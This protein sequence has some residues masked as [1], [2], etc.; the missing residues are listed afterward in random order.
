MKIVLSA[1]DIQFDNQLHTK[2]SYDFSVVMIG[3]AKRTDKKLVSLNVP[4]ESLLEKSDENALVLV[5]FVLQ[6]WRSQKDSA[7]ITGEMIKLNHR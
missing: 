3:Q 7:S 4:I 5:E 1:S 6:T 2:G